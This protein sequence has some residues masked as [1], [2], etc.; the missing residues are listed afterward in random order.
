MLTEDHIPRLMKVLGD[1]GSYSFQL[2]IQLGLK[3]RAMKTL[4]EEARGRLA[5]F[6]D[7]VLSRWLLRRDPLPT[8]ED[9]VTAVSGPPLKDEDLGCRLKQEFGCT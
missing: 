3:H 4:E 8:L 5:R 6:M 7:S 2:G 9:L 1:A